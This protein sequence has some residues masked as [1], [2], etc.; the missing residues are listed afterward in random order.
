LPIGP[1]VEGK[2]I[3]LLGD[4]NE[5]VGGQSVGEIVIRSRYLSPGYW[6]NPEQ[7]NAVFECPGNGGDER[8]LSDR[9]LRASSGQCRY[10]HLG[11]K[12]SR[13]KVRGFRIELA[14]IEIALLNLAMIKESAVLTWEL[15]NGE[16]RLIAYVVS[17]HQPVPTSSEYVVC[18]A[19]RCPTI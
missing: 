11:R 8:S 16:L 15:P 14:E 1:A 7:T 18:Y 2:E 10:Q 5:P 19:R 6:R 13:V 9:R 17:D 12:D 4:H 3:F